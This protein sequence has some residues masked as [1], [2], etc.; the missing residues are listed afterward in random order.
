MC[1]RTELRWRD[2]VVP[3]DAERVAGLVEATGFFSREEEEI[4]VELVEE[5]L[6]G[7]EASGYSF[8]FAESGSDL[9]GYT[10][11]GHT[12][13]TATSYDLYWIVVAPRSQRAGIGG[14]LL[15]ESESRIWR[16]GG[17]QIWVDTSGRAQYRPTREFYLRHGYEQ[18][19]RL[20]DFYSAGD[21]KLILVK[22]F[23]GPS[24][25]SDGE[26][27]SVMD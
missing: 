12:P 23:P 6:A 2:R 15:T 19:A 25:V 22:R 10:C 13:G 27:D 1:S 20:V 8:L 3:E 24:L 18:A 7:G 11:Y 9:V 4:A 5:R 26:S 21:D 17:T 14:R 16:A